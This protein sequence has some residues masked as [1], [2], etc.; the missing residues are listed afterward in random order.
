MIENKLINKI[1][2]ILICSLLIGT[3]IFY[4]ISI[5]NIGVSYAEP[6]Y[7]ATFE[8]DIFEINIIS[9]E[10]KWQEM[11]DNAINEE[12][13]QV[14]IEINGQKY[15]SVGIRPK[16]NSS[17]TQVVSSDSDR[18][19]FKIKMDQ[20]VEGQN[21]K[22]LD[23]FVVNNMISDPTYMKEYIS[24]DIMK[25][26]GVDT[27][28]NTFVDMNLNGENIGLYLAVESYNDSFLERV[29]GDSSGELYSVKSMEM[30]NMGDKKVGERPEEL[31]KSTNES[32]DMNAENSGMNNLN[33]NST[34]EEKLPL[35]EQPQTEQPTDIEMEQ[36]PPDMQESG[37]ENVNRPQGGGMGNRDTNGGDLVYSDDNISSYSSILDNVVGNATEADKN[38]VIASLKDLSEG[39]NLED[40]FEI[41]KTLRYLA[42]H[43]VVVNLDSY[44]SSMAQNYYLYEK[45]GKL[46]VLPWDYNLAFGGFQSS[47]ASS[48]IN[49][50][51]DTPVSGVE[52]EDRP[53]I[54]QLLAVDEYKEKYYEYINDILI[55][56]FENGAIEVKIQQID[57]IINEYVKNDPTSFTTYEQ[58]TAAV[59]ELR[60]L[61]LLRANSLRGQLDGSVPKTTEAQNANP[62]Q[63]IDSSSIDLTI[64]GDMKGGR[65]GGAEKALPSENSIKNTEKNTIESETDNISVQEQTENQSVP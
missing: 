15:E 25:Y 32:K 63:L 37:K 22:G 62:D 48:V 4:N 47:S 43:T 14:D 61:C 56:Y 17:L 2:V 10:D 34:E 26:I 21:Y 13:I 41:D 7:Q 36:K 16:G 30:G 9:N 49:F 45:E 1:T 40:S 12:Y 3:G 55:G 51:I 50:P 24:Y 33:E 6:E 5:N 59:I 44:S 8:E 31:Q 23:T 42:A 64:I 53:L 29:Y 19:S 27:P 35:E 28:L 39:T 65:G 52:M 60:E 57:N 54:N 20:Y 18:Y 46:T 38:R 58:Y 11:L